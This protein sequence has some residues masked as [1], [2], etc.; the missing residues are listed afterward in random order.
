MRAEKTASFVRAY[1][2]GAILTVDVIPGTPRSEIASINVWRAS[3]KIKIASEPRKGE[4]NKELIGFVAA[5][6]GV[7]R[8]CIK[9]MSG[10]RSNR[11]ELYVPLSPEKAISILG[12]A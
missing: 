5:K 8:D 4:A 9:I 1:G 11:K 2:S 3:L 6:L 10:E 12:G 7:G